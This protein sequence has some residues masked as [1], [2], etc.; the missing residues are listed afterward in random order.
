MKRVQALIFLIL[1]ALLASPPLLSLAQDGGEPPPKEEPGVAGEAIAPESVDAVNAQST[2]FSGSPSYDSGWV[3]MKRGEARTLVHNLGGNRDDYVV[4]LDYKANNGNGINQRYYG[5]KDFGTHPPPGASVH[6]RV[7][8]YWRS[9]STNSITIYRRGEDIYADW[10]R[11][12][13]WVDPHPDYDSGWVNLAPGAAATTLTHNLGG[14]AD[15][16]VVDMQYR[17]NSG[18]V[19]QRYYGGADFGVKAFNGARND[20]RVG[21]YWRSLTNSTITL[22][23]RAEDSYAASVRVRIWRRPR[24]TYDSGWITLNQGQA[25]LLTHGIGGDPDHYV[26]D[27]QYRSSGSGVNQRYY[28]GADFGAYPPSGMDENDRVG[29]YWRSLTRNRIAVYRRPEDIY[30]PEVRIRIWHYWQPTPPDYDSGWIAIPPDTARTLS[31]NLGGDADSYLVRMQYKAQDVNGVNL[32]YYGGA[33]FGVHPA[34][35]HAAN[36]RVGVYWRTLTNSAITLYRRPEDSYAERTRIRIWRMPKPDYDSGWISISPNQAKTL[37]HNLKGSVYDYLVDLQYKNTN[38]GVNQR[39]F[40]GADFGDKAFGGSNEDHRVGVYWRTLTNSEIT[41]YR[42]PEDSYASQV[43]VRIWRMARPDYDSGW[44]SLA[45][46]QAKTFSHRVRGDADNYLLSMWQYDHTFNFINQRHYGGADFGAYPP[47]GYASD[48]R[49]GAYWR[50]LD[51]DSVV[52]YRRPE[53][54]FADNVRIR[55]WDYSIRQ[56]LPLIQK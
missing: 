8:A 18:D 43:R 11:V 15:D 14:D 4:I 27:M 13:I 19:N 35:G 1:I 40:G 21:A 42:R 55:I 29:A 37:A 26:V 10:V 34:P 44:T 6:D 31:H 24:P 2:A 52:V 53:D 20:D 7:G 5:G 50:S 36:D 56:Y 46:D 33:D 48:D 22:F 25:A 32:R 17:T 16:Y 47:T 49:V 45:Q 51:S 3:A 39:Y 9:L 23:R 41:I 38:S 28:G 30:A 54:G 12:R